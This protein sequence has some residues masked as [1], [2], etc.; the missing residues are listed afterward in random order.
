LL[1]LLAVAGLA[2]FS[3]VRFRKLSEALD[4]QLA[5]YKRQRWERPVLRGQTG[6]GNAGLEALQVVQ[7]LA[8]LEPKARDA[9][10]EQL[11]YGQAPTPAQQK[12]IDANAKL[13]DKLR[14][15][16]QLGWSM[17]EVQAELGVAAPTPKYPL[18]MDA[19]LMLLGRASASQPEECV[20]I[21]ADAMRLGQDLVPGAPLEA[22]SVSA[23][24]TGVATPVLAHC[25]TNGGV[26]VAGRAARELHSL[27]THPPPVG[28]GIELLDLE[29]QVE[30][31]SLAELSPKD[32][33]DSP[34]RRLRDRPALFEAWERF[35]TPARFRN[36]ISPAQYPQSLESWLREQDSRTRSGLALISDG[37]SSVQGWLYDDMRGQALLRALSVGL[38]TLAERGR[39]QRMPRE[40]LGLNEAALCDPFTGQPLKWRVSQDGNELSVWSVGEDR[41]DDKG[42]SDW[43]AQA[44]LDVVVH[45][46]VRPLENPETPKRGA[47]H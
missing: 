41:R 5:T 45:L 40:P 43:S 39:R 4:A 29:A 37:G 22:A 3:E 36:E 1:L 34:L 12:L 13:L 44:P 19:V 10:A 35:E 27:A 23:R 28:G 42:S 20:M 9:L 7:G 15:A 38:A 21:A 18:M 25:V 8:P 46:P 16:T 30:L 32:S 26:D 24:I 14:G 47:R 11:Y 31:R 17:N 33:P 6:E 2:G